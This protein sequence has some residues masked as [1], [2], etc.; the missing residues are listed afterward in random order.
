MWSMELSAGFV[1][2][3]VR[4]LLIGLGV[5]LLI[6]GATELVVHRDAVVK[7]LWRK[8][9]FRPKTPSSSAGPSAGQVAS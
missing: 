5:L 3:M 9:S 4:G 2:V 7:A 8:L 1:P 6:W